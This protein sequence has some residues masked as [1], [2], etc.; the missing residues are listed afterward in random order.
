MAKNNSGVNGTGWGDE[1]GGSAG[2]VLALMFFCCCLPALG[3]VLY[4]KR[5]QVKIFIEKQKEKQ[6][7]TAPAKGIELGVA[8]SN[9]GVG[10]PPGWTEAIDEGSGYPYYTNESSGAVQWDRPVSQSMSNPMNA[11]NNHGRKIT[12][13]PPGW[14][15]DHDESGNAYYYK[16][17]EIQWEKPPGN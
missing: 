14:K 7:D 2:L 9:G 8:V 1:S 5:E 4:I 12:V 3:A 6:K 17:D 11:S 13:M 16:G 15:K 10:L